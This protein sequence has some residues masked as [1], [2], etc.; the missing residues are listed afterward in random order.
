MN[1]TRGD[2]LGQARLHPLQRRL[3]D[4]ARAAALAIDVGV[5]VQHGAGVLHLKRRQARRIDGVD[6]RQCLAALAAQGFARQSE[7]GIS[8]DATAQGFARNPLDH[9]G[10]AQ[11]VRP[12]AV[13][14]QTGDGNPALL[15]RLQQPGLDRQRQGGLEH[16]GL[17]A[18]AASAQ[19]QRARALRALHIEGP[20]FQTGAAGQATQTRHARAAR[21]ER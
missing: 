13:A 19:D 17:A 3:H 16:L 5:A 7:A 10:L 6:F 21:G 1:Q 2:R 9:I 8:G 4:R 11:T 12:A 15:R 14:D 18:P 20:G